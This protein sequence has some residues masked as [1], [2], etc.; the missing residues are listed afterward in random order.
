MCVIKVHVVLFM[1]FEAVL[2]Y[3]IHVDCPRILRADMGTENSS[4]AIVFMW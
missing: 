2:Y 3:V 4:L 1:V